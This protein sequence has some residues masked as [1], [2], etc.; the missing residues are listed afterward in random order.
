MQSTKTISGSPNLSNHPKAQP[1][2][3][4]TTIFKPIISLFSASDNEDNLQLPVFKSV[5]FS[6]YYPAYDDKNTQQLQANIRKANYKILI[7]N[8]I[9][10][11][12]LQYAINHTE[13]L[14]CLA[15][16][17]GNCPQWYTKL[18]TQI[19]NSEKPLT[20]SELKNRLENLIKQQPKH[21][22]ILAIKYNFALSESIFNGKTDYNSIL[23]LATQGFIPAKTLLI[24][25]LP[26][27]RRQNMLCQVNE[28]ISLDDANE[29]VPENLITTIIEFAQDFYIQPAEKNLNSDAL[30]SGAIV[31]YLQNLGDSSKKQEI[32]ALYQSASKSYDLEALLGLAKCYETGCGHAKD[33]TL[34]FD[35][36]QKAAAIGSITAL[37]KL[38]IFYRDGIGTEKNEEKFREI[39]LRIANCYKDGYLV[40]KNIKK[41]IELYEQIE[42]LSI[43]AAFHLFVINSKNKKDANFNLN[44][45]PTVENIIRYYEKK[46][47]PVYYRLILD[48]CN[49]ALEVAKEN[50]HPHQVFILRNKANEYAT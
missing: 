42:A 9:L 18:I 1:S 17:E 30:I 13:F 46:N 36:Y 23:F 25:E 28:A 19:F 48:L 4:L 5:D 8:Q 32:F 50:I 43:E 37:E 24:T 6:E 26:N 16:S 49:H 10:P 11:I 34:A 47:N 38:A 15:D 22:D 14:A 2:S 39:T 45:I 35:A 21:D 20:R 33:N 40:A 41:A 12:N 27:I 3:I 29:Y 31:S 44:N 7:D